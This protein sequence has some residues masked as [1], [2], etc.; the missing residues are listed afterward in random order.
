MLA[1]LKTAN[2]N[3]QKNAHHQLQRRCCK[4]HTVT[5]KTKIIVKKRIY[6]AL[7]T[8]IIEETND[9]IGNKKI[10]FMK[11]DFIVSSCVAASNSHF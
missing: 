8:I 6:C 2:I 9:K 3:T 10:V 4:K 5:Q 7:R 1:Q 11:E